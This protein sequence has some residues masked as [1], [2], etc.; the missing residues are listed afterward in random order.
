MGLIIQKKTRSTLAKRY[1]EQYRALRDRDP[2]ET[3]CNVEIG[4]SIGTIHV[5]DEP[6]VDVSGLLLDATFDSSGRMNGVEVRDD[7]GVKLFVE[8]VQQERTSTKTQ[9]VFVQEGKGTVRKF[10]ITV[11]KDTV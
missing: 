9:I 2:T 7:A 6:P 8:P 5:D 10:E 1:A 3:P 11:P 4:D